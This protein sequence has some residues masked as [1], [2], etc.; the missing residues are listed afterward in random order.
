ML[1]MLEM[2]GGRFAFINKLLYLY[3]DNNPINDHK[4]DKEL[5][6]YYADY[7]RNK[8][9]YKSLRHIPAISCNEIDCILCNMQ[10][11]KD[12]YIDSDR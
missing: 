9:K 11:K 3:N 6:E 5:Q 2:S 7:I 1:P 10:C 4:I 8:K 12:I